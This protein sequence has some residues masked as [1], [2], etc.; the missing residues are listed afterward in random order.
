MSHEINPN[1]KSRSESGI[2]ISTKLI[3]SDEK[4]VR[5]AKKLFGELI[6]EFRIDAMSRT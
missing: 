1:L 6:D 2:W 3:K 5:I 4:I